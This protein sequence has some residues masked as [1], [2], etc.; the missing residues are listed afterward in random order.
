MFRKHFVGLAGRLAILD[1]IRLLVAL[2]CVGMVGFAV[3]ELQWA[4]SKAS[5]S[6]E[7]VAE[8][9]GIERS[10]IDL[11]TGVRGYLLTAEPRFLAPTFAAERQLPG[12]LAQLR[13]L[14][15]DSAGQQRRVAAIAAAIAAYRHSWVDPTIGSGGQLDLITNTSIGKRKVDALRAR[16]AAFVAAELGLRSKRSAHVNALEELVEG[17]LAAALLILGAIYLFAAWWVRRRVIIPLLDLVDIVQRFRV[18]SLEARAEESGYA[19]VRDLASAFNSMAVDLTRVTAALERQARTDG[20][21]GLANRRYF[22]EELDRACAN[23][24]RHHT[25]LS[26]LILDIDEFKTVNDSLGHAA[27]DRIL[28]TAA[29]VYNSSTRSG[30]LVARLGGDEFAIMLP[31]TTRSGANTLASQIQQALTRSAAD[32]G[33]R[34]TISIGAAT[35]DADADPD[36]LLY[37]ADLDMYAHKNPAPAR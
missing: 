11:E 33:V 19:E 1:G 35:A 5:R 10:V 12:E 28:K 22:N 14:V 9:D 16:F 17:M 21:T 31:H 15:G 30:D 7:V 6:T 34:L 25:P 20:L 24:R 3:V 26:L 29:A 13:R 4:S 8:S 2:C 37:D 36:R 27:G 23:A 18:G 32:G